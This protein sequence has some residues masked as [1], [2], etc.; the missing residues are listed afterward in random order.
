MHSAATS[1]TWVLNIFSTGDRVIFSDQY[2]LSVLA[3]VYWEFATCQG[4]YKMISGA[5]SLHPLLSYPTPM[6]SPVHTH[7]WKS[8][9]SP[10]ASL[11][12]LGVCGFHVMGR[13]KGLDQDSVPAITG[14]NHMALRKALCV[15]AFFSLLEKPLNT[16]WR[17]YTVLYWS[18]Q[19]HVLVHL[20]IA[21]F[22]VLM[23]GYVWLKPT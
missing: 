23:P 12:K 10:N 9:E 11:E 8:T 17:R 5:Y 2:A 19:P 16:P 3:S 20:S 13:W 14:A 15:S 18:C 7:Q 6:Q 4:V 1:G 21:K 22:L